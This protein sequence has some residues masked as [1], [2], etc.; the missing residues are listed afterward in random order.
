MCIGC[1]KRSEPTAGKA[2]NASAGYAATDATA[3]PERLPVSA[4][5]GKVF[6]GNNYG[7]IVDDGLTVREAIRVA[8]ILD[9][10]ILDAERQAR[11]AYFDA[12]EAVLQ[13]ATGQFR[14]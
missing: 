13:A 1:G 5:N 3:A 12:S 6:I 2:E 4:H 14:V 7:P 8:Y 11:K 10:V 9:Q